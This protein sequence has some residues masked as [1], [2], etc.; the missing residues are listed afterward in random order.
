[1]LFEF[2]QVQSEPCIDRVLATTG[3]LNVTVCLSVCLSLSL[4]G[5]YWWRVA[6]S[7]SC[8]LLLLSHWLSGLVGLFEGFE[9]RGV[10]GNDMILERG[11]QQQ[12][13][14]QKQLNKTTTTTTTTNNRV[15]GGWSV[16]QGGVWRCG[17]TEH[18]NRGSRA[19]NTTGGCVTVLLS[20]LTVLA[21]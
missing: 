17:L 13:H 10:L 7:G 5:L 3:R 6:I 8:D 15:L 18:R 4:S 14:E 20:T 19:N 12:Q 21:H 9:E 2:D 16:Q 11:Q 1:M